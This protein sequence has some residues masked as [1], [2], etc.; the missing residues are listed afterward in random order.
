MRITFV[1]PAFESSGG[2][3]IVAGHAQM[4]A[5]KG[6]EVLIVGPEPRSPGLRERTKALLGRATLP[7]ALEQSHYA[8]AQVPLHVIGHGGPLELDDVPDADIIIATFWITAEW[9]AALPRKKGAKVHFIQHYE[10]FPGVPL[11]R[12]EAVWRLPT[13]KIA[14]A[15]WLVDL[16]RE[17]FGIDKIALVPNS[18]DHDIFKPR[19][20]G[21]EGPLTVGFLFSRASFKDVPTS[22]RALQRLKEFEPRVTILSF[23]AV[24]PE[25]RQM[26]P[27]C[28]F[29]QLPTQHEIANIY[30]RCHAWLSTSETEGFN[31]PPLEAMATGC[32]A[33]CSK[34]GR[35][36]EI[37]E[38]GTNGYLVDQGDSDGFAKALSKILS[39]SDEAWRRMSTAAIEAV[40]HPT[41]EE[42]SKLFE[43]AL[44]E[45]VAA[46]V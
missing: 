21:K 40:A 9:I 13:Y 15:Q 2:A 45:S 10:D 28:E 46:S 6:H 32:P 24:R 38:N 36:L 11:D 41:W 20:R 35:P 17:R 1:V 22:I 19:D 12:L 43:E 37:I 33:V 39:L 16:G 25:A 42:S 29:Q 18:I 5:D 7:A 27:W 31:L 44:T 8:R 4:L 30:S 34:T 14:I 26:P 23:G 3:R